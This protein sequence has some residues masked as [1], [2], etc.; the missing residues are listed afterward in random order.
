MIDYR[1][2]KYEMR[3]MLIIVLKVSFFLHQYCALENHIRNFFLIEGTFKIEN[4]SV[5]CTRLLN[6]LYDGI[7]EP[8][9]CEIKICKFSPNNTGS[10]DSY[11]YGYTY[12][13]NL[14][15]V[16][17]IV[18]NNSHEPIKRRRYF[19]IQ[20]FKPIVYRSQRRKK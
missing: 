17:I 3:K 14:R 1:K 12:K 8:S 16:F 10:Y 6:T 9:K 19:M 2:F 5:I 20:H 13:P 15:R 11:D 7:F 18:L 4:L